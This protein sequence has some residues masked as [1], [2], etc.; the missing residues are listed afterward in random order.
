MVTE[1]H[2]LETALG[3]KKLTRREKLE[4]EQVFEEA[5]LHPTDLERITVM[6]FEKMGTRTPMSRSDIVK[7]IRNFVSKKEDI[8][9]VVKSCTSRH[10][11]LSDI[12]KCIEDK[13]DSPLVVNGLINLAGIFIRD[14]LRDSEVVEY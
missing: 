14:E 9:G 13:T 6:K 10:D 3:L 11:T 1:P 4:V 2:V 5:L 12:A 7:E 8:I